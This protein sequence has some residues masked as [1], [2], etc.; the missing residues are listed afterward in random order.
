MIEFHNLIEKI[1][2]SRAKA[3]E[4]S[5]KKGMSNWHPFFIS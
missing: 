4:T 1:K 5:D 2:N 3:I